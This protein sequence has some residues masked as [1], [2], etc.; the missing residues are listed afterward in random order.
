MHFKNE[1]LTHKND[2]NKN[3]KHPFLKN[4][5]LNKWK[6]NFLDQHF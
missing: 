4:W 6:N 2:K 5:A 3:F 1:L